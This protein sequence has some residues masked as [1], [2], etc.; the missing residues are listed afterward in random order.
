M[1]RMTAK[2]IFLCYY[3]PTFSLQELHNFIVE[4]VK[5]FLPLTIITVQRTLLNEDEFCF[6]VLLTLDRKIDVKTPRF[7]SFKENDGEHRTYKN[8]GDFESSLDF[9]SCYLLNEKYLITS[10]EEKVLAFLEERKKLLS[11]QESKSSIVL[12]TKDQNADNLYSTIPYAGEL[13]SFEKQEIFLRSV[14]KFNPVDILVLHGF[15]EEKIFDGKNFDYLWL[16][17]AVI[18]IKENIKEIDHVLLSTDF[19]EEQKQTQIEQLEYSFGKTFEARLKYKIPIEFKDLILLLSELCQ[20]S[21]LKDLRP[22]SI[23]IRAQKKIEVLGLKSELLKSFE[24]QTTQDDIYRARDDE[25]E[26]LEF[27]TFCF[28]T[29]TKNKSSIGL[30]IVRFLSNIIRQSLYEPEKRKKDSS[31]VEEAA[32]DVFVNQNVDQ[33]CEKLE[34]FSLKTTEFKK[35]IND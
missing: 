34:N 30:L 33:A 29:F 31:P 5:K 8:H 21:E 19:S 17:G 7:F 9:I 4:K 13:S 15:C 28:N 27:L 35:I 12:M 3:K 10:K 6:N 24:F 18:N 16:T 32:W 20:H 1:I 25:Q 11:E 23:Y 2:K 22:Q 26:C 14:K